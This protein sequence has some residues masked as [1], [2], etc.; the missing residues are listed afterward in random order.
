MKK[1]LLYVL[2][3][4]LVSLV[5]TYIILS[6]I[7]SRKKEHLKTEQELIKVTYNT[8]IEAFK[9]HSN[10][11]YFNKINTPK[12]KELLQ[13]VN[14][15]SSI[16]KD[17]IRS[18]LHL[19]FKDMYQNMSS[20]KLKQLHFHLK[21]NES[22][23][24]FHRPEKYGDDL[25]KIRA[26]INYVNTYHEPINGFEEGRIF[27]GY[28]FVYPLSSGGK[29]LGS[30]ETS[31]SMASIITEFRKVMTEEID[32]IISK[33]VVDTKVFPNEKSNYRQCS[34]TPNYY[35]ENSVSK[36]GSPLIENLVKNYKKENDID[37]KIQSGEVFN[38]FGKVGENYYITTFFPIKN[39]VTYD[40]V[41]YIIVVN[42][43]NEFMEYQYQYLLFLAILIILSSIMTLF[44]YRIDKDKE[45]LIHQ[46]EIL[47]EVQKIG[48]LGYWELDLVK[49]HLVWSDETYH[50]FGLEEQDFEEKYE[51]FL[52]HIHPDDVEK[53]SKAYTQS[54]KNKTPN[55]IEHRIIAKNGEIKYVEDEWHH[56]I[57]NE[58][59]VI[60]SLGTIHDI[61]Q[62]KI[63]QQEIEKTKEQFESLVS[64][65]PDIVYRCENDDT[66]TMLY[67]NDAVAFITGY[68][69]N[70]LKLNRILSYSSIIH[71]DDLEE[72]T[73]F[74]TKSISKNIK[75]TSLEYRIIRKDKQII[76]V[77][78]SF[79]I[80]NDENNILLEGVISDITAQKESYTK[81]QKFIDTQESIVILTNG[82]KI[83][84]ANK[85]LFDFLGFKDLL[86]FQNEHECICEL[87]VEDNQFFHLGKISEDINWVDYMQTLPKLR[88]IVNI[89]D[90]NGIGHIFS[91]MINNFE[92]DLLIVSF[93]DISDTMNEQMKL[94]EKTIHDKLTG[95]YNREYFDLNYQQYIQEA[96]KSG[97]SLGLAI[98]DIDYFK[99]IND[100]YGHDIGDSVLVELVTE[101]TN[102]SRQDDRLIRW[103]G[104]E[105]LL[106]LKV[107]S[108][109][110]LLKVLEHIRLIISNHHF[111]HIDKLTC[112]IGASLYTQ[113][114]D[115]Q[116]TIKRADV[117]LYNAKANGRNNVI[118]E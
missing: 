31:V 23:L 35:H 4:V 102:F 92:K 90:I 67:L 98:L 110:D 53:V 71:P 48:H 60:Q 18:K 58:G 43:Y 61:T 21:N 13:N 57:D 85:R 8:V 28:R 3:I 80:I 116:S 45:L 84:F 32:F 59:N 77:K 42:R 104:E 12:I 2:I 107:N 111:E 95:A 19:E 27:N 22:F 88:R 7:D 1:K 101:I 106:L 81:L 93:T 73:K 9:V 89:K 105:F 6:L 5:F 86:H 14:E 83:N 100:T 25:T 49:N 79:E 94:H 39:A 30:V 64:H 115:I 20:F 76:W 41:A 36:G 47:E 17:E 40:S 50:I 33:S 62:I 70:E 74:L 91:V 24:R 16:K 69:A 26:T 46:D 103:G 87:F 29:H 63:Y 82:K 78:D 109:S 75:H 52:K 56:T 96:H 117:A 54:V 15:S 37:Q 97:N 44:V 108:S 38:F 55:S 66:F 72:V 113:F 118:I 11:L 99:K 112:S 65:M 68:S 114:E 51:G 10:I 34:S